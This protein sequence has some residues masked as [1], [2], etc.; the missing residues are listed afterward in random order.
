MCHDACSCM[1]VVVAFKAF[2]L[3]SNAASNTILVSVPAIV[4]Y[5]VYQERMSPARS[6]AKERLTTLY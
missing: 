3:F 2:Y 1:L 5:G 4:H 6:G